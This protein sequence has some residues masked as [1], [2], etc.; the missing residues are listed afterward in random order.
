MGKEKKSIT[1]KKIITTAIAVCICIG[2]GAAGGYVVNKFFLGPAVKVDSASLDSNKYD[3]DIDTIMQ[4]Y[5]N[6]KNGGTDY[7]TTLTPDEMVNVG[8]KLFSN[9]ENSASYSYGIA[10]AAIVE[11]TIRAASI[12]NGDTYFEESISKSSFVSVA[13]RMYQDESGVRLFRGSNGQTEKATWDETKITNYTLDDFAF[14]FGKT[15][16]TPLIY[17]VSS[18]TV[19][20]NKSKCEKTSSG[21][22]IHL[23]FKASVAVINYV[24]Q[25]KSISDLGEFPSFY[26]LSIDFKLDNNCLITY[27]KSSE[28]YYAR[29]KEGVGTAL[30]AVMEVYYYVNRGD[31]IPTLYSDTN[32]SSGRAQ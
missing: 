14:D 4:K 3:A 30:S 9:Y 31:T 11:Q 24:K 27:M 19:N 21:Y 7:S 6:A 1:K 16:S 18:K 23:D 2:I 8:Y 5:T 32:Y 22:D 29:T 13:A 28:S 12:R 20:S 26:T 10:N 17:I 25:M 15:P